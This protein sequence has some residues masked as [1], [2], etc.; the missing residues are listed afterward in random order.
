MTRRPII[1]AAALPAA[2]LTAGAAGPANA[3]TRSGGTTMSFDG[4]DLRHDFKTAFDAG[5]GDFARTGT[6]SLPRGGTVT[7]EITGS[8]K[9]GTGCSWKGTGNGLFSMT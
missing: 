2:V 3:F 9:A 4:K 8:C 1:A 7:Y 6:I 5:T